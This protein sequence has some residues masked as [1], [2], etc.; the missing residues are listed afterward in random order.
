MNDATAE[1]WYRIGQAAAR[2]D[3][4]YHTQTMDA[5]TV[6]ALWAEHQ[7]CCVP[8]AGTPEETRRLRG[9]FVT[10][11]ENGAADALE[12][13]HS[14]ERRRD[15]A[16]GHYPLPHEVDPYAPVPETHTVPSPGTPEEPR[17]GDGGGSGNEQGGDDE[18]A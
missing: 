4:K 11:Y 16:R 13:K 1:F 12:G 15:L 3:I 5:E 8:G 10:G 6:R 2:T 9:A 18:R 14:H 17:A 7:A